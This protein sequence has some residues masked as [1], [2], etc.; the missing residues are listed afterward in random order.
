M[1][2]KLKDEAATGVS[3]DSIDRTSDPSATLTDGVTS[4]I[5]SADTNDNY[6]YF[7]HGASPSDAREY[8]EG[9]AKYCKEQHALIASVFFRRLLMVFPAEAKRRLV[10]TLA[11]QLAVSPYAPEELKIE[12]LGALHL[13]PDLPERNLEDQLDKLIVRPLVHVKDLTSFTPPIFILDSVQNM[14]CDT[15]GDVVRDFVQAVA[16]LHGQ[17]VDA[18]VVITG[19]GYSRIIKTFQSIPNVEETTRIYPMAITN[20]TSFTSRMRSL[21]FPFL[22]W[23]YGLSEPIQRCVEAISVVSAVGTFSTVV[24]IVLFLGMAI[25]PAPLNVLVGLLGPILFVM[26]LPAA[27]SVAISV[28]VYREV[29]RIIWPRSI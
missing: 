18:K 4:D 9:A 22:N 7:L 20:P 16:R 10:P 25:L 11:Y 8:G 2:V 27:F 15:V 19:V 12:I 28:I 24:P 21:F 5:F 14:A 26:A 29:A 13:E 17:G 6:I 23:K 1:L 3:Y